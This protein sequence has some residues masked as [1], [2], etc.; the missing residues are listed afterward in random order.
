MRLRKGLAENGRELKSSRSSCAGP[1]Q[2]NSS[3]KARLV[4]GAA[5]VLIASD[6]VVT[7]T[8][9][10]NEAERDGGIVRIAKLQCRALK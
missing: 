4:R 7:L 6:E 1:P 8:T 10:V 9:L 2:P 3:G 5:D